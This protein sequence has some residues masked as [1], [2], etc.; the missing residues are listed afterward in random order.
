MRSRNTL[1]G[2]QSTT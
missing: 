2:K 1:P